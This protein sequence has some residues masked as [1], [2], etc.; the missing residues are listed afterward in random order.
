MKLKG[1]HFETTEVIEAESQVMP[2]TI[3]NTT[4]RYHLKMAEW[5]GR[6]NTHGRALFR[7]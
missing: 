3:T 2:N 1:R 6:M 7:G 5:L 4:S